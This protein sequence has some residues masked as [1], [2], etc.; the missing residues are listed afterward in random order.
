MFYKK[1]GLPQENEIVLCQVTKIFPNSVFANLLEYNDSGMIHISEVSPGRIRNLRDYV[2]VNRQIVC[3]VLRI[4]KEKGHIDLSLRRVNS[5]ERAQKLEEI[6]QELKSEALVKALSKKLKKSVNDL[7]KEVTKYI[8]KE[9]THLH[10]CFKEIVSGECDLSK[11]GL[12]T[13]LAKEITAA[14][15]DKFKPKKVVIGGVITMTSTD[16]EG[17][18]KIKKTLKKI[19]EIGSEIDI[20]YLGAGRFKI[21]IEDVDY[22]PAEEKLS[23]VLK[24]IDKF[25][26]K[27]SQADFEREKK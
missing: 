27:E 4:D 9:Y 26:D 7:Y 15:L 5:T 24:C 23:Q 2:S 16:S 13:A 21:Q 22:P 10:L 17:I 1:Q 18:I 6:K 14:V 19:E 25:N 11:M 8:F 20:F 3:K 12:P